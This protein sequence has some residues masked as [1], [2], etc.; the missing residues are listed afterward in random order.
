MEVYSIKSREYEA[1]TSHSPP[2]STQQGHREAEVKTTEQSTEKAAIQQKK[3]KDKV[4]QQI[5]YPK[6]LE[7]AQQAR[8]KL[9]S[10]GVNIQ[11]EINKDLNRVVI[12]VL[13]PISGEVVRKIP[14]ETFMRT[15]GYLNS[16]KDKLG[17]QGIE[18][19]VKY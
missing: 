4:K 8:E 1:V 2:I 15:A 12:K 9:K 5:S 3:S 17:M 10:A 16:I 14:P 13:D 19:D 18:V 6:M 11:F 7:I